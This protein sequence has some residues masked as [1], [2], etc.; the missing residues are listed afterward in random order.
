MKHGVIYGL[1]VSVG[2]MGGLLFVGA[3][4]HAGDNNAGRKLG[5]GL[6]NTLF[7]VAEIPEQVACV[8]RQE[9]GGAGATWGVVRGVGKFLQREAVGIYEI[10]T[11]PVPLPKGYEPI[12]QPEFV[13][14][15]DK[16]EYY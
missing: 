9:G 7:G 15:G 6:A 10:I 11:F 16:S 14:S 4:A 2:I 8:S 3:P 12:M 1:V 13:L 5:R